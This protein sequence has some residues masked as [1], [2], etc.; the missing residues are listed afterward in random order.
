MPREIRP[1]LMASGAVG[2]E[3]LLPT[4]VMSS[5]PF[6]AFLTYIYSLLTE[7]MGGNGLFEAKTLPFQLTYF[8]A[9]EGDTVFELKT[10]RSRGKNASNRAILFES[11]LLLAFNA[12]KV[13]VFWQIFLSCTVAE[14]G[15]E[16]AISKL[17]N[18][19]SNHCTTPH[20]C[21]VIYW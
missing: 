15:C 19:Y 20:S 9:E 3:G 8:S 17:W 12:K 1:L 7:K 13:W 14:V 18:D 10:S 11:P 5:N 21:H 2:T 4:R 6:I 16:S